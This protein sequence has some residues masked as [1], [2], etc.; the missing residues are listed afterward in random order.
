MNKKFCRDCGQEIQLKAE[1]CPYCSIRQSGTA[2][3]VKVSGGKSRI[4]AI[5]LALFLGGLGVHKFYL[6]QTL[7][8]VIM[9]L[10]CWTFIPA[11][12]AL[13]EAVLLIVMDDREFDFKF[14]SQLMS[15]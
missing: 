14:N 3:Y 12:I 8:A 4:A 2:P 11:I 5:L 13:I 1:I 15:A 7:K 6:G 9:L 10:F